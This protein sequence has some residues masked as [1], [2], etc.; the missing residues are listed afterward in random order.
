MGLMFNRQLSCVYLLTAALT[1][2]V[3]IGFALQ[4]PPTYTTDA[5][6]IPK[7]QSSSNALS[8]L[9]SATRLLGLST[10]GDQ[11]S[12]FAKFQKYWG[13][14]EI[15]Q[16]VIKKYP[17]LMQHM[18]GSNWDAVHH[19][20]YRGPRTPRQIMAVPLDWLFGVYP[21]FTPT[22]QDLA[23]YIKGA[24]K[25]DVGD[26]ITELHIT[27][28]SSDP[29]FAQWFLR[30]VIAETD[31]AVRDAEQRRYEDFITFARNRLERET[32][33]GYRDALIDSLRQFEILKYVFQ[34]WR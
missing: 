17:D 13:S 4:I 30:V 18:Y 12:S 34:G 3:G 31:A 24:V 25:I 22:T 11:S 16:R 26:Q 5:L 21:N 14:R 8:G 29:A 19:D 20:W 6:L 10:G 2:A 28:N 1:F 27:Y 15:A 9:A 32:N 23:D 33:V 7:E